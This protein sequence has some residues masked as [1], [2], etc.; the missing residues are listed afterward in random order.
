MKFEIVLKLLK[1]QTWVSLLFPMETFGPHFIAFFAFSGTT[2]CIL[3][4][5]FRNTG[6][7][8][9]QIYT[10]HFC[11]AWITHYSLR[12]GEKCSLAYL[13]DR[14]S[15]KRAIWFATQVPS[16]IRQTAVCQG[17][18]DLA[19]INAQMY[20]ALWNKKYFFCLIDRSLRYAKTI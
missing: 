15:H 18:W 11:F 17:A 12:W 1:S 9:T 14:L 10:S 16:I 19:C 8:E 20:Q 6:R 4:I 3:W 5:W 13:S 2:S 7:G